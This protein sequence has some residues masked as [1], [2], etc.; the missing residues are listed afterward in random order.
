MSQT[1]LKKNNLNKEDLLNDLKTCLESRHLSE[2]GRKEVFIGKA[3]LIPCFSS[4]VKSIKFDIISTIMF[5]I[6]SYYLKVC[7]YIK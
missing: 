3:S 2:I 5:S 1:F 7:L 6:N 4:S